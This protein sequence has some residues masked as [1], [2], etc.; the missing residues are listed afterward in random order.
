MSQLLRIEFKDAWYHVVDRR[1]RG[2]EISSDR[3]D[4]SH[5]LGTLGT[6]FT[7]FDFGPVSKDEF[8]RNKEARKGT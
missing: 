7:I 1:R 3:R 5:S 8:G 6:L 4:Y 2:E